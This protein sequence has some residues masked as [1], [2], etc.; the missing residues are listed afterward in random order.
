MSA[1]QNRVV[2]EPGT[3]RRK[4]AACVYPDLNL[5][6]T[7]E[8]AESAKRV[9]ATKSSET[10][11]VPEVS[12][13]KSKETVALDNANSDSS[14]L[15]E[16]G[17]PEAAQPGI[18]GQVGET[19]D[20]PDAEYTSGA[21]IGGNYTVLELLG[22]GGMGI[23]VKARDE[24][25][26][27]ICAIKLLHPKLLTDKQSLMRFR[28]EALAS[29]SLSHPNIVK[30]LHFGVDGNRPF[31]V[32]ELLQGKSLSELIAE[33]GPLSPERAIPILT[34][35]CN[36]LSHAHSQGIVHRDLKPSNVVLVGDDLT[37]V[38]L[39]D[40]GIAKVLHVDAPENIAEILQNTNTSDIIG[41][42]Y[43]M[44]PEQC[45]MDPVDHRSDLYSLGCLIY[46]V[47]TGNP[48][49]MSANAFEV[50]FSHINDMPKSIASAPKTS[51]NAAKSAADPR[52]GAVNVA[53]SMANTR[54]KQSAEIDAII[55]KCMAKE[56][57]NRF[58]SADDVKNALARVLQPQK[59]SAF[60]QARAPF[61]LLILKAKASK[62]RWKLWGGGAA[63]VILLGTS[64]AVAT[65][66]GFG[67]EPGEQRW[68]RLYLE[69][70][71][72]FNEAKWDAAKDDF[73]GA[74]Q[75]AKSSLPL[76]KYIKPSLVEQADL[77]AVRGDWDTY[78]A[79]EKEMDG[80]QKRDLMVYQQT[81]K[82]IEDAAKSTS[83]EAINAKPEG[84]ITAKPDGA[85]NTKQDDA[86]KSKSDPEQLLERANDTGLQALGTDEA[87]IAKR[88]FE[89]SLQLARTALPADAP[90]IGRS[91][92]N[93]AMAENR[94]GQNK[95]A[96]KYYLQAI[97]FFTAHS[98]SGDPTVGKDYIGMARL[99]FQDGR[100]KEAGR[101]LSQALTLYR[102]GYGAQHE[103]VA[104][105][106]VNL[107][108]LALARNDK[109]AALQLLQQARSVFDTVSG[110]DE[111]KRARCYA[112]ISQVTGTYTDVSAALEMQQH[113][114]RQEGF[115]L[116]Q[117]LA[118][119]GNV[120][121]VTSDP[122]GYFSRAFVVAVRSLPRAPTL[123][124]AM[125]ADLDSYYMGKNTLQPL[126]PLHIYRLR[127]DA[128]DSRLSARQRAFDEMAYA[129]LLRRLGENDDALQHYE[130]A[131]NLE[132]Q[133]RDD[134][135]LLCEMYASIAQIY[136]DKG[137]T[138]KADQYFAQMVSLLKRGKLSGNAPSSALAS[139]VEGRCLELEKQNLGS[140]AAALR[141]AFR[142]SS[143]VSKDSHDL[144]K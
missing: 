130:K 20:D 90:V 56:R 126:R 48:P 95:E 25:L 40:F 63:A 41:S 91:L 123:E 117:L 54:L 115:Y 29:G 30:V 112:L 131:R 44:S 67:Q 51:G 23:V 24:G 125:L 102:N 82:Q 32:M 137:A 134:E 37:D 2:P 21:T 70:Q 33:T 34:Q 143:A 96:E 68:K 88:I 11:A 9:D 144:P 89:S 79:A 98:R 19:G 86:T 103:Q 109:D 22:R 141:L 142:E 15:D 16:T 73:E 3:A 64:L 128:A 81:L 59:K 36:A 71:N 116:A 129:Y 5:D 133:A 122:S 50:H 99:C 100:L 45:L 18:L 8:E 113:S 72:N 83:H 58:Q 17:V 1:E 47:F 7:C 52:N 4:C 14:E 140:A 57:E 94:L 39:V 65:Y 111:Q 55:L 132:E 27:R 104:W 105:V 127:K 10:N 80:L 121:R 76:N 118:K 136:A 108:E 62:I 12:T 6:H 61:D 106:K 49:F 85:T 31:L 46:A 107:A 53:K 138:Q 92:H 28:K 35:V 38:R 97:D 74:I 78:N 101:Y 87:E 42:P 13:S 26:N 110:A 139:L 114:L 93:L 75:V 120:V 119:R 77:S 84:A 66:F 124:S 135:W 60:Q 43:Y 69:G